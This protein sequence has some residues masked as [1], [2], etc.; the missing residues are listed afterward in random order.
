MF[1]SIIIPAYNEEKNIKKT[2]IAL[3]DYLSKNLLDL[4]SEIIIVSDGSTDNTHQEAS[5]HSSEKIK[6]FHYEDNKG[7]GHA[8]RYGFQKSRGDLILFFDA[9]GDFHPEEIKKFIDYLETNKA[10]VVIGS[11]R[12]PLSKLDYPLR[13]KFLSRIAQIW[14]KLMFNLNIRD[15]Q[16]GIKLFKREVLEKIIPQ[17]KVNGFAFDIELLVLAA[18]NNFKITEAPIILNYNF[19]GT[20][21]DWKAYWIT[22]QDTFKIN[23]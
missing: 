16:V 3:K 15:T 17:I 8:L 23:K 7:K 12:H 20:S 21:V 10:D 4:E 11:K 2:V 19:S 13:R 6:I 18:K 1:L 5:E 14:I 22:F 9:G